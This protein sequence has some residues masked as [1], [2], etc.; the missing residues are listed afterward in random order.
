M[1]RGRL[2][3][4]VAAFALVLAVPTAADAACSFGKCKNVVWKP[5]ATTTKF[6]GIAGNA[7][8]TPYGVTTGHQTPYGV[9]TGHQ[10]PYGVTAGHQTPYG[11]TLGHQT[12]YGVSLGHQTN[13]G[14]TS[15]VQTG[16]GVMGAGCHHAAFGVVCSD[17]RLKRDI[18]V[19]GHLDD[20]LTLY[21]FKYLWSDVAYV[22]VMAQDVQAVDPAAVVRGADGYFR[23]DY[24]RL[25]LRLQ[26][27]SEWRAA[28]PL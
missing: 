5:G 11:V 19:V 28:T 1:Q 8:L 9:T 12:S 14:V 25:G 4:I 7:H 2:P 27:W 10:T 26:T 16:F 3:S 23:V 20:S 13:Y 6:G 15:G 18:V 22:G 21:R 17:A 24:R